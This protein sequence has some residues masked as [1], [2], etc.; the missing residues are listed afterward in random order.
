MKARIG[1]FTRD[2]LAAILL[3]LLAAWIWYYSSQFP[4]L[5][6]GYPGPKLFPRIIAV[7]LASIGIGI[8]LTQFL[9]RSAPEREAKVPTEGKSRMRLI[10]G[11]LLLAIFPVLSPLLGFIPTLLIVGVLI[12]FSLQVKWWKILLTVGITVLGIYLI[13]SELLSVPL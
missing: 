12:G 11:I 1:S 6:E 4:D 2:I 9:T 8:G 13:F 3:L 10:S 5:P 7:G